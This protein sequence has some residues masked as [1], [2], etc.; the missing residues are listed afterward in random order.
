MIMGN[1]KII[2]LRPGLTHPFT[3]KLPT[4]EIAEQQRVIRD[5]SARYRELHAGTSVNARSESSNRCRQ[6]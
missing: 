3:V 5:L 1:N 6:R 2:D 4:K